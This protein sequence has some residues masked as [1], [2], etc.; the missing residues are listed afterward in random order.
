M[1]TGKLISIKGQI[2]E[3]E[4]SEEKPSIYDVMIA[5]E[6]PTI[7]VEVYTSASPNSFFCLALTNITSLHHGSIFVSTGKPIKIPVGPE[8]LGRVID[9]LG[10]RR[11]EWV[12]LKHKKNV[13]L[14]PKMLV[15]QM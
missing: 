2:L 13:Q 4:F 3:I 8:L 15:L 6:D 11:M 14:F 9:T 12:L 7:K 10:N 5:Q 1:I